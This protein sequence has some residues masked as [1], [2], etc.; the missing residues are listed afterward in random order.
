MEE[1]NDIYQGLWI[2]N[3]YERVHYHNIDNSGGIGRATRLEVIDQQ[4]NFS[5]FKN[6]DECYVLLNKETSLLAHLK[7]RRGR[8]VV[9][10]QHEGFGLLAAEKV[11][12][13]NHAI[14]R[15]RDQNLSYSHIIFDDEGK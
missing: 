15:N 4:G 12:G 2:K 3:N 1:I 10:S 11:Q 7:S 9:P 6:Q 13:D 5:I 8:D 14:Q